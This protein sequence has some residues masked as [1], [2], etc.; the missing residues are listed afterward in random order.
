MWKYVSAARTHIHQTVMLWR[1]KCFFAPSHNVRCALA[2]QTSFN[3]D[4]I[5]VEVKKIL[6]S[7]L[8]FNSVFSTDS[9]PCVCICIWRSHQLADSW[10]AP[11]S[12][13]YE[14]CFSFRLHLFWDIWRLLS[15]FLCSLIF[16]SILKSNPWNQNSQIIRWKIIAELN[17]V[18]ACISPSQ[19]QLILS[20]CLFF[21]DAIRTN[22]SLVA[23][24]ISSC[25]VHIHAEFSVFQAPLWIVL[26]PW[27]G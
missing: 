26:V 2:F 20:S 10:C 23:W 11:Y 24:S 13:I 18:F 9:M 12:N 17:L 19:F 6:W 22:I 7:C 27:C 15:F 4:V 21:I 25:L 1:N 5:K 3:R 16:D 8:S 14:P